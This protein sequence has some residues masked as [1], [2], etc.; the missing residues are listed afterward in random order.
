MRGVAG[1]EQLT[2]LAGLGGAVGYKSRAATG[3][4]TS[5]FVVQRAL[6]K[7]GVETGGVSEP[8]QAKLVV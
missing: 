6:S 5:H 8:D 4:S 2:I 3:L 1:A 7:Y